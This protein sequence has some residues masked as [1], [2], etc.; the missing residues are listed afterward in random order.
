MGMRVKQSALL[1]LAALGMGAC[2]SDQVDK[3]IDDRPKNRDTTI[4]F[5]NALNDDAGFYLHPHA[6]FG[7]VFRDKYKAV[8]LLSEDYGSYLYGWNKDYAKTT[9]GVRNKNSNNKSRKLDAH[10]AD[11]GRTW[12]V[13]W[14]NGSNYELSVFDKSPRN[15]AD[16]ISVRVLANADMDVAVD[17]KHIS[18]V[19][20][21]K[22]STHISVE[23][24]NG[25]LS[26][27]NR[28]INLCQQEYGR[29][30]LLVADSDGARVIVEE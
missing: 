12:V 29:S 14:M 21:G 26:I 15:R 24:C 5:V 30:Y 13:A 11:G 19:K 10:L 9:F 1:L 18:R 8:D 6:M 17:G 22:V 3:A 25:T 4:T 20:S 27:A 23:Q 28:A 2:S 16:I 7:D